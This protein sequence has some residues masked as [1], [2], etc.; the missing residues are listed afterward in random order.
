MH[1]RPIA[2]IVFAVL[3]LTIGSTSASAASHASTH[4]HVATHASTA[5]AHVSAPKAAKPVKV[6]AP[7]VTV[8]KPHVPKVPKPKVTKL[9]HA[10]ISRLHVKSATQATPAPASDTVHGKRLM[11]MPHIKGLLHKLR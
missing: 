1:A 7:H 9:P 2:V 8:P 10:I 11:I 5:H 4:V 6:K 3:A